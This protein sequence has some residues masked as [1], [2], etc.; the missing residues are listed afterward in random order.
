MTRR[1]YE[2]PFTFTLSGKILVVASSS[3]EAHDLVRNEVAFDDSNLSD[4]NVFWDESAAVTSAT[5]KPSDPEIGEPVEVGENRRD[6][7][8]AMYGISLSEW[9]D[10]EGLKFQEDEDEEEDEDST[11]ER[12]GKV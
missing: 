3:D 11:S 6:D 4:S 2:V 7:L 12:P 8:L 10:E 5:V 9:E 1:L